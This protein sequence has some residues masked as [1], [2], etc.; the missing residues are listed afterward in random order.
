[1][2]S[3]KSIR[4]RFVECWK[5][6]PETSKEK[7]KRLKVNEKYVS[8]LPRKLKPELKGS[9]LANFCQV[10]NYSPSYILLGIGNKKTEPNNSEVVTMFN[11][12]LKTL[13]DIEQKDIDIIKDLLSG[14]LELN[15]QFNNP[16]K[17]L[18]QESQKRIK[19]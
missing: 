16:H 11:K 6:I 13:K 17:A 5:E 19:S 9:L 7:A 18:I 4:D 10:Y 15:V 1:M 8:Q 14:M 3:D 2:I 12:I